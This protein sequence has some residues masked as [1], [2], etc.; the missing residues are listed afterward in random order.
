M[1][2]PHHLPLEQDGCTALV[3]LRCGHKWVPR[4]LG[5]PPQITCPKCGHTAPVDRGGSWGGGEEIMKRAVD[6][7]VERTWEF[8]MPGVPAP[9][10]DPCLRFQSPVHLAVGGHLCTLGDMHF[11]DNGEERVFNGSLRGY[12]DSIVILFWRAVQEGDEP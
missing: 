11:G 4:V 7:A 1:T 12:G 10:G 3:C 6:E 5:H 2:K 9:E 8:L